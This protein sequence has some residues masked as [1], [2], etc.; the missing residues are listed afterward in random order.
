MEDYSRLSCIT[1][2]FIEIYNSSI[3]DRFIRPEH[4][5]DHGKSCKASLHSI[6]QFTLIK[7]GIE[8]SYLAFPEYRVLFKEAIVKE[9]LDERFRDRAK[10][11]K[12][13][14]QWQV[15]ADVAFLKDYELCGLGEVYT[16]DE[17]HGCR[18]SEEMMGLWLTPYHKLH[19]T[20]DHSENVV[21]F[22]VIVNVFPRTLEREQLPWKDSKKRSV[23][24]WKD[25]W[26]QLICDLRAKSVEVSHI[27]I[28]E[29]GAEEIE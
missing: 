19:H 23:I 17:I 20:I 24:E 9:K 12:V 6:L 25:C 7:A 18:P 15:K 26:K 28:C 14:R 8:C 13:R 29:D 1:R 11:G 3:E 16:L 4:I 22:L 10:G 5:V 2:N 21:K 27:M